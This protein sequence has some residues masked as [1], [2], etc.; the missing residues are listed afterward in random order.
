MAYSGS[1]RSENRFDGMGLQWPELSNI[2][3]CDVSTESP[4]TDAQCNLLTKALKSA[5]FANMSSV[6]FCLAGI[7]TA[8]QDI[9]DTLVS[10]DERGRNDA[11]DDSAE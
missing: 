2:M 9:A 5:P 1:D 4:L 6:V 11:A 7:M 10:I 3:G 8:L